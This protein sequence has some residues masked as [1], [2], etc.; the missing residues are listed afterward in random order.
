[1]ITRNIHR[2]SVKIVKA[3]LAAEANDVGL[4]FVIARQYEHPFRA[5]LQ[6]RPHAVQP[7]SE[8]RKVPGGEIVIGFNGHQFLERG[9]VAV[10]IGEDEQFHSTES[11]RRKRFPGSGI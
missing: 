8:I 2:S 7:S 11:N 6:D 5:L 4:R 1:M 3:E 9:F 10:N